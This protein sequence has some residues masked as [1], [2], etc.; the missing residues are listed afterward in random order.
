MSWINEIEKKLQEWSKKAFEA[1][2]DH[3]HPIDPDNSTPILHSMSVIDIF[4]AI[5]AAIEFL[6]KIEFDR[7]RN[8]CFF[9]EMVKQIFH[10]LLF[11]S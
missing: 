7:E 2:Q 5:S 3:W 4:T 6:L 10:P 8:I 11:L 1:D 9:L